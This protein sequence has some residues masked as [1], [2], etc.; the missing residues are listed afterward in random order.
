MI[1]PPKLFEVEKHIFPPIDMGHI[2]LINC[3]KL[4]IGHRLLRIFPHLYAAKWIIRSQNDQDIL[5]KMADFFHT[6]L[7]A[8]LDFRRVGSGSREDNV[9]SIV[10]VGETSL[11]SLH[12]DIGIFPPSSFSEN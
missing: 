12:E 5:F 11:K 7:A 9:P 8:L 10:W 2:A 1:I 6:E 3:L 4:C